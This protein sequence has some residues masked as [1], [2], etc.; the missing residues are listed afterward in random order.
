MAR[1]RREEAVD[2][3][4]YVEGNCTPSQCGMRGSVENINMRTSQ[5]P[6][7]PPKVADRGVQEWA[8]NWWNER[9][10]GAGNKQHGA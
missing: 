4:Y 2:E 10:G 3:E 5:A 8:G 7:S 1:C 6:R 9:G